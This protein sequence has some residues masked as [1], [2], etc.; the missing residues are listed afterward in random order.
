[1]IAI[2]LHSLLKRR[3]ECETINNFTLT[4]QLSTP[5][6]SGQHFGVFPLEYIHAVGVCRK[7]KA[8]QNITTYV[9]TI[10][11]CNRWTDDLLWQ[12]RALCSIAW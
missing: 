12:Y 1:L 3:C 11:Q 8:Y 7:K 6:L 2:I 9:T 5:P 4:T 10:P